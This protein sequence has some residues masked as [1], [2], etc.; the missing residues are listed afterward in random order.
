MGTDQIGLVLHSLLPLASFSLEAREFAK[1]SSEPR[2]LLQVDIV[3]LIGK[4]S[5]LLAFTRRVPFISVENGHHL[6]ME[7]WY[8]QESRSLLLPYLKEMATSIFVYKIA[9]VDLVQIT[10]ADTCI[11]MK[12]EKVSNALKPHILA[13]VYPTDQIELFFR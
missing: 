2:Y 5:A 8:P 7:N 6:L 9:A 10:E 12:Q 3:L 13:E 11:C 1:D 4:K